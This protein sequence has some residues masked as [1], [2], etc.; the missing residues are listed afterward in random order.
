MTCCLLRNNASSD[1][2]P[3]S[4]VALRWKRSRPSARRS[5]MSRCTCWRAWPPS[6]TRTW[7][8]KQCRRGR[9][10]PAFVLLET[11]REYGL[12]RLAEAGETEATREAHAAYYLA[13]A[14]EA[15]PHLKGAEQI[16]WFA[17]LEQERA[18]LRAALSWLL[19]RAAWRDRPKRGGD[20][21]SGPCGCAS[22]CSG[23]GTGMGT[24]ER[25]ELPGA[26][27]DDAEG[28]R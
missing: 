1:S 28:G 26:S 17:R 11:I 9:K 12:E 18:N 14:E 15:E 22:P 25:M 19:E 3:S 2:S 23:S 8:T 20:R 4:S 16:R 6:S 10:N 21:R 27:P 24:S 13:L 5:V 7:C